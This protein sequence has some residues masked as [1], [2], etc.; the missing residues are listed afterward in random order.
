MDN[1][2]HSP[3]FIKVPEV[4]ITSLTVINFFFIAFFR[5]DFVKAPMKIPTPYSCNRSGEGISGTI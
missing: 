3:V 5:A 4:A 2:I 1:L